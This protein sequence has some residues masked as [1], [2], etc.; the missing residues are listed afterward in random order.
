MLALMG[1]WVLVDEGEGAFG[2]VCSSVA[3]LLFQTGG[4]VFAA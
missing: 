2:A 4:H 3:R 1:S